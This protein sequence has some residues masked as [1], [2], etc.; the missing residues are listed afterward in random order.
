[1]KGSFIVIEG[2][3]GSGKGSVI[4]EV[5]NLLLSRGTPEKRIILTAEPT[6]GFYGKKVRELLKSSADPDP[7]ARNFL[8][9][10]VADR[11]EHI[12]KVIMPSLKERKIIL[13]DRY[14]YST[15]VYQRLQG[16]PLEEI[17]SL[18]KSLPVPD[19]VFILDVPVE[20]ALERIS[21]DRKRKYTESFEKKEFLEKV[22]SEFLNLGKIFPA[23]EIIVVDSSRPLEDVSREI[24]LAIK[25]RV[26]L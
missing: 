5:N 4:A 19:L 8:S 11:K 26:R 10:Y 2:I 16:I 17:S 13:C 25:K 9:L 23:E 22:R 21:G 15:F 12:E 7:F 24:F 14:K 18:H 20:V 3:D 1:M 6:G